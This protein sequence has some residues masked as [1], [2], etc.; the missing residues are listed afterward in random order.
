MSFCHF[1]KFGSQAFLQIAYNDSL[2][3]YHLVVVKP[4]K[5]IRG[6]PNLGQTGQNWSRDQVFHHFLKFGS[7]VFLLIDQDDSLEQFLKFALIS[8]LDIADCS[9]GQCLTSR[10]S[11]NL[12]KIVAQTDPNRGR[13]VFQH[14]F[15]TLLKAEK[16]Y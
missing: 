14:F 13:N 1:I 2:R 8:F 15:L 10:Q 7:I 16:S 11:S 5:K 12:K 4:S 3:Q 9:L 6:A